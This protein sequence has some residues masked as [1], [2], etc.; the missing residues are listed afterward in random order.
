MPF[1]DFLQK[2]PLP[3]LCVVTVVLSL[4]AGWIILR[5]VR[6]GLR[7]RGWDPAKPI[8]IPELV[9]V[10]S[11]LFAL[12]LSFSAAGVWNDWQQAQGAVRREALALENV[13]GLANGLPPERGQK[14]K[15]RVLAYT[16][17]AADHEWP[18]MARRADTDDPIFKALDGVLASLT[19]E[20]SREIAQGDTSPITPML[21]PQ[22]F[23]ARSARLARLNMA[24]SSISEAQW[25]ALV[26]LIVSV[27][28][29]VALIY[30]NSQRIQVLAVNLV[31]LAGA[32]AFY[33]L[34]AH[35]RPFIGAI[36]VSPKPL[37]HC[38]TKHILKLKFQRPRGHRRCPA[39]HANKRLRDDI[40][41]SR[42]SGA[43]TTCGLVMVR[44]PSDQSMTAIALISIRQRGSV[45]SRTTCTVVVAGLA[46]LKYSA[47]TRLSAS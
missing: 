39:R 12:M 38:T 40:G 26:A 6:W 24:H 32:A 45:A 47:H 14:L 27:Q 7:V 8:N 18:A 41:A 9:T 29:S 44:C 43:R 5:I 30:N 34:L 31:S 4:L 37:L 33:V 17:A 16:K 10:T 42:P 13:I 36:T 23:E 25:F 46:S 20:L 3:I 22:I 1:L 21:L 2:L 19:V 15:E 11:V 35:D 28:V